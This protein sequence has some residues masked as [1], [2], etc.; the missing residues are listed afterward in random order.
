VTGGVQADLPVFNQ[1]QGGIARARADMD[2]AAWRYRD[3]R[4]R[5]VADVTVARAQLERAF[6]SLAEYRDT[7][8]ALRERDVEAVTAAYDGGETDYSAVFLAAQRLEIAR[9]REVELVA[10]VRRSATELERAL[11]RRLAAGGGAE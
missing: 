2:S 8:V 4:D 5:I 7:I 9:L 3:L 1:N 6:A 10:E 11:G